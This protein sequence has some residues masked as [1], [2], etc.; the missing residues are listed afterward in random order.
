[1]NGKSE[2]TK[3][4]VKART[5]ESFHSI[6]KQVVIDSKQL[7][8]GGII[9]WWSLIPSISSR[10]ASSSAMFLPLLLE[11]AAAKAVKPVALLLV[12]GAIFVLVGSVARPKGSYYE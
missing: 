3:V 10:E 5:F 8:K 4:L 6:R 12:E 11:A 2:L 9:I 1:M 7:V